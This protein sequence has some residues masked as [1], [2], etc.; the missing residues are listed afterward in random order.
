MC[1]Y[2]LYL[3]Y[4]SLYIR[5]ELKISI[6]NCLNICFKKL[7]IEI[8]FKILIIEILEMVSVGPTPDQVS[9]HWK[10]YYAYSK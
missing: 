8:C 5:T 4:L 10:A 9:W 2:L 6:L 7:I 1:V 3:P